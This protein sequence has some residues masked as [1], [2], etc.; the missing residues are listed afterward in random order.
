MY[1]PS[2]LATRQISY[3]SFYFGPDLY[4]APVLDPQTFEVSVYLPGNGTF[5]HVWTQ[6]IYTGGQIITVATP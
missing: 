3:Q 1:H 4:V 6:K 2:D 5:T